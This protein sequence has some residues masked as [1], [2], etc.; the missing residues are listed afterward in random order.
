MTGG[1]FVAGSAPYPWPYDGDMS[2]GR[3][4]L[5]VVQDGW[6]PPTT[7]RDALRFLASDVSSAGGL[8]VAVVRGE[9]PVVVYG[10]VTVRVPG[11]D[12]FYATALDDVLR[13]AGRDHLALAGWHL[14]VEVHSTLRS[15]NDRGYECVTLTD[16]CVP[17]DPALADA[18]SSMIQ[19][20]GG[21]F[22][23]VATSRA[24]VA[25]LSSV[26]ARPALQEELA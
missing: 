11:R 3:F 13:Q 1:V 4:A 20:S 23:A 18:S 12:G 7:Q 22:G 15:A 21:I 24:L 2:A 26:P 10:D 25:A 16:A 6:L 14:E 5:L 17:A 8:V 19:M 9:A